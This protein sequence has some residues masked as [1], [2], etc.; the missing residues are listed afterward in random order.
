MD[1]EKFMQKALIEAKKAYLKG[2][3]PIGAVIVHGD[4]IVSRGHNQRELW[5]DPTAHAEI[6]A[7][8]EASAVLKRWRLTGTT[9]YVTVEPC[10]MCAGAIVNARIDRVV[11]GVPDSKAG[12][13][14]TLMNIL[15]DDRL[16]HRVV[17]TEGVLMEE[18]RGILQQFF[19]ELRTE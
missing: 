6:I 11:Y 8:R 12:A 13:A 7:I 10:P 9:L 1:D 18:C 19:R 17:V 16:N 15:N 3:V 2:E 5:Q 4:E 14:G